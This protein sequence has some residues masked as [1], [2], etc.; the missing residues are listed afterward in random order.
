MK[1]YIWAWLPSHSD[2]NLDRAIVLAESLT[3]A[4]AKLKGK[5]PAKVL[6]RSPEIKDSV[7]LC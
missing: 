6:R 5:V 4:R 1:L 3:D 7:Y 2:W